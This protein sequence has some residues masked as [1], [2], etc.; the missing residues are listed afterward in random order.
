VNIDKQS[1]VELTRAVD[2]L[3][4]SINRMAIIMAICM[5]ISI[6]FMWFII[7]YYEKLSNYSLGSFNPDKASSLY[8]TNKLQDLLKYC[9]KFHSKYPHDVQIT[10]YLGLTYYKLGNFSLARQYFQSATELNPHYKES[11]EPYLE[12]ISIQMNSVKD[13]SIN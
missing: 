3:G 8:E 13:A 2:M 10:F 4:G 11:V 5:F 1:V 6:A 9:L 7:K 12:E